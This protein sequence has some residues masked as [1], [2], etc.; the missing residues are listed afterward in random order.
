MKRGRVAAVGRQVHAPFGHG[1]FGRDNFADDFLN[2]R[3]QQRE[4]DRRGLAMLQP[5]ETT[6]F[7]RS[8]ND[9]LAIFHDEHAASQAIAQGAGKAQAPA[10]PGFM[11][12]AAS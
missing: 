2:R 10:G 12:S 7:R 8:A 1:A 6:G 3:G 4:Q 11:A 9:S 5:Q